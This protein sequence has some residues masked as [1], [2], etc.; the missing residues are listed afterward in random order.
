[1][2]PDLTRRC[3]RCC[4]ESPENGILRLFLE[5]AVCK[6]KSLIV[7]AGCQP[8]CRELLTTHANISPKTS[9]KLECT[10]VGLL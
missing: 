2:Q 8:D 9:K 4:I 1:M 10:G 6:R 7:D 5:L 3:G